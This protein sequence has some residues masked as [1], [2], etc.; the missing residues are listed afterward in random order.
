MDKLWEIVW[1][2]IL[3]STILYLTGLVMFII[4]DLFL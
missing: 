1:T 2:V 3:I 4:E